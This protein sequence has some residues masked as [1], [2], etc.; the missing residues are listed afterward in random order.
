MLIIEWNC[1][2][3]V[4]DIDVNVTGMDD[5]LNIY[6]AFKW[7]GRRYGRYAPLH[8]KERPVSCILLYIIWLYH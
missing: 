5:E 8:L 6:I 3:L 4:F 7:V 1:K 2:A